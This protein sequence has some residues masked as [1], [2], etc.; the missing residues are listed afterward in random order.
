MKLNNLKKKHHKSRK[1]EPD[2]TTKSARQKSKKEEPHSL[3]NVLHEDQVDIDIDDSPL[4]LSPDTTAAPAS[5]NYGTLATTSTNLFQQEADEKSDAMDVATDQE[6]PIATVD[7]NTHSRV[8]HAFS[9]DL[10]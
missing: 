6:T 3:R 5:N 1:G 2:E 8:N 9:S 7:G 10:I 4:S